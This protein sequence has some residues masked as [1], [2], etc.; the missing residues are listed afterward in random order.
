[1]ASSTY[2]LVC[3]VLSNNH[4]LGLIQTVNLSSKFTSTLAPDVH[5][6]TVACHSLFHH[7]GLRL[8][9]LAHHDI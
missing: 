9:V 3:F 8:L 2:V 4:L 5:K 6:P 7:P 1:M